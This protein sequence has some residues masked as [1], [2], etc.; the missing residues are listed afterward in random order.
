VRVRDTPPRSTHA[1]ARRRELETSRGERQ[2]LERHRFNRHEQRY[3]EGALRLVVNETR[4]GVADGSGRGVRRDM[5]VHAASVVVRGVVVVGVRVYERR[6]QAPKGTR[7]TSAA[8]AR[9]RTKADCWRLDGKSQADAGRMTRVRFRPAAT[10]YNARMTK[11]SRALLLVAA[12]VVVV[13]A[14]G[15]TGLAQTAPAGQAVNP[16]GGQPGG[17]PIEPKPGG[18]LNPTDTTYKV[19]AIELFITPE[20]FVEYKFELKQGAMMVFNWKATAPIDVDFHTVP[21]GKPISASETFMR[22]KVGSGQGTYRAP[23][24]GLHG[25]YWKNTTKE[26]VTIILNASGFFREARMFSG[27]PVGEPMEVR[28]PEPPMVF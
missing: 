26:P 16:V 2:R 20:Q 3:V 11:L 28:D 24:D 22:G 10:P 6:H 13:F 21:A 8:A 27:D 18:P 23:Y 9:L 14:A 1:L 5:R 4:A 12:T 25:W 17:P 15:P 7:M 19:D